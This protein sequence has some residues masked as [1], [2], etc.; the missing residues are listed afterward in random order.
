M[1]RRNWIGRLAQLLSADIS[2]TVTTCRW[3]MES[4]VCGHTSVL[5]AVR[6]ATERCETDQIG[7]SPSARRMG[8]TTQPGAAYRSDDSNAGS[9]QALLRRASRATWQD[10]L[11]LV[12][13]VRAVLILW[14][15]ASWWQR[16]RFCFAWTFLYL[17]CL[18]WFSCLING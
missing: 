10:G 13:S 12:W 4:C 6:S 8:R 2:A 15:D 11:S 7:H 9:R 17:V 14:T 3:T 18:P 5:C 16:Y 1:R